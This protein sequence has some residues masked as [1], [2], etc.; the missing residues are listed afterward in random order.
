[1]TKLIDRTDVAQDALRD[2]GFDHDV[3]WNGNP[4]EPFSVHELG[5]TN[6]N[7][8][9]WETVIDGR[10]VRGMLRHVGILRVAWILNDSDA[11]AP[12]D[13]NQSGR[14]IVQIAR[15]QNCD[16]LFSERDRGGTEQ[17]IDCR[18]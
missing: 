1:M 6:A 8:R 12:F 2:P 13:S 18:P 4:F 7:T 5:Q 17:R 16:H 10:I 11:A 14:A 3:G 15:E 9:E